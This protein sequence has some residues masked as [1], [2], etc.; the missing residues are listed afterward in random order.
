VQ[1]HFRWCLEGVLSSGRCA[2]YGALAGRTTA[3]PARAVTICR[4]LPKLVDTVSWGGP[5]RRPRL[6]LRRACCSTPCGGRAGPGTAWARKM[7]KGGVAAARVGLGAWA[8]GGWM[9]GS[10]ERY[11]LDWTKGHRYEPITVGTSYHTFCEGK[12]LLCADKTPN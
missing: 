3:A 5:G 9:W 7:L 12:E 1:R 8:I 11:S 6:L 10:T 2:R 4:H